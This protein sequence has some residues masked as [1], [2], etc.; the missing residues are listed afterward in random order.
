VVIRA[1][2][3]TS[4]LASGLLDAYLEE[5]AARLPG[6]FDP[7]RSVS[8]S[9]DGLSPPGGDFLVVFDDK[10]RGVGCGGL[11]QLEPDVLEIKR[12]WIDPAVRGRG[13]SR[14][15]L[16]ALEE[17]ARSLGA[18]ELRL[19][20]NAS[21]VEAVALYRASGFREIPS[22]NDNPFASLWFAK[23]VGASSS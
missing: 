5:I 19:D 10:G 12:M 13:L 2:P 9:S 1:E 8:A 23:R 15:L 6:G 21:L 18:T 4:A 3:V 11:K 22:Y 16:R 7:S 17:R 14:I 20:T